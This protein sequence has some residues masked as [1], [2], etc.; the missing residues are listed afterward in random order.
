MT[1]ILHLTDL[2]IAPDARGPLLALDR[3]ID[4]IA[5]LG[6][7]IDVVVA[8]GDL[9]DHGDAES[10]RILAR[11][12][13][14]VATPVLYALGNHDDRA[15]FR[16]AFP[17]HPG[18]PD[19]PLD[20]AA[21]IAG[22]QFVVLDTSVPGKTSG[23]LGPAQLDWLDTVLAA[24]AEGP[25]VLV[26]HHPPA[27]SGAS[28]RSWTQIDAGSSAAL[29]ERVAGRDIGLILSGHVHLNRVRLWTKIPV[30]TTVGLHST[31][32][33]LDS[34]TRAGGLRITDGTALA[35]CD[36]TRDTTSVTYLPLWPG[37][38]RQTLAADVVAGLR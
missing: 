15:A 23:G 34:M 17:G 7:E 9:T 31:I 20:H 24:V 38:A 26:L 37:D 33:M 5:D 28:D 22:V 32:D 12:M 30:S 27:G 29:A 21:T 1:R 3:A 11:R 10:Y 8:S 6:P 14:A 25:R 19:G 13:A 4:L 18:A 35:L 36:V 2:H 16:A